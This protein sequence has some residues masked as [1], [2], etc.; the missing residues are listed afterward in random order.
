[1]SKISKIS[2]FHEVKDNKSIEHIIQT[3][4]LDDSFIVLEYQEA[5]IFRSEDIWNMVKI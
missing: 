4:A 3:V 2:Y 5:I 1:M